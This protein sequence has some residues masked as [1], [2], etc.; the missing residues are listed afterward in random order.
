M[1]FLHRQL[2][3][4]GS[5]VGQSLITVYLLNVVTSQMIRETCAMDAVVPSYHDVMV[6]GS[7]CL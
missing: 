4:T 1:Y 2:F 6:P 3:I 7:L 5:C